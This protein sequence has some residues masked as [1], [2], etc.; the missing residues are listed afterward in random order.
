MNA[1]LNDTK[2]EQM[3]L[4]ISTRL[5]KCPSFGSIMLNKAL[6]YADHICFL[7]TGK[8]ISGFNYVRQQFGPTPAPS[9]F[10]PIRQRMIDNGS[11]IEQT[12][13]GFGGKYKSKLFPKKDYQLGHFSSVE[14]EI[15]DKVIS[16]METFTAEGISDN[17]HK[18]IAWQLAH[19]MESLPHFTYLL[20][21]AELN[22]DDLRWA[23]DKIAAH[24]LVRNY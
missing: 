13:E 3:V 20:T 9:E 18:E 8:T 12:E 17:S 11:V 1:Q 19:N 15:L 14:R 7:K 5:Q 24:R 22:Q 2:A 10:M 16:E 23:T 6:Y 4:Y 21:K